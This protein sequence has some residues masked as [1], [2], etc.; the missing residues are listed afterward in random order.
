MSLTWSYIS[1]FNVLADLFNARNRIYLANVMAWMMDLTFWTA[2]W[3]RVSLGQAWTKRVSDRVH[4]G[5]G[6]WTPFGLTAK[7]PLVKYP[8]SATYI[9]AGPANPLPFKVISFRWSKWSHADIWTWPFLCPIVAW[10]KPLKQQ[11]S[12]ESV[13]TGNSF[14]SKWKKLSYKLIW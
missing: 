4:L 2:V 14:H 6:P 12:L 1:P 13:F 3:I 7:F 10:P 11:S 8:C 5:P 9:V